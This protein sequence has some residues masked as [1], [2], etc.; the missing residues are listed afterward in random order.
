MELANRKGV[1]KNYL[2]AH[3]DI[4]NA[5]SLLQLWPGMN[6]KVSRPLNKIKQTEKLIT[7]KCR[8]SSQ[9]KQKRNEN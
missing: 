4:Y 1:D 5:A 2:T 3:S 8:Q 9:L 6:S 7:S